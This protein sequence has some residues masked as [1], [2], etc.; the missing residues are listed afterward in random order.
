[1]L[2]KVV[3]VSS[4]EICFTT[5]GYGSGEVMTLFMFPLYF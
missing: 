4:W 3:E 5:G 2:G 1:M